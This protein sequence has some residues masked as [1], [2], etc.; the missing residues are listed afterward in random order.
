MKTHGNCIKIFR[1]AQPSLSIRRGQMF[2]NTR[3]RWHHE[4]DQP[5]RGHLIRKDNNEISQ[6]T[7]Q[8]QPID[9]K[10]KRK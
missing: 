6:F 5:G 1:Q 7:R 4:V 3:Q 10:L 8:T 2:V 9:K